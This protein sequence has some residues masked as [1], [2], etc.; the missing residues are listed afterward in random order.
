MASRGRGCFVCFVSFDSSFMFYSTP[1][2]FPEISSGSW[3]VTGL[4]SRGCGRDPDDPLSFNRESAWTRICLVLCTWVSFHNRVGG[5]DYTFTQKTIASQRLCRLNV[6]AG[7]SSWQSA[8]SSGPRTPR[9]PYRTAKGCLLQI[10]QQPNNVTPLIKV[11]QGPGQVHSALCKMA[12]YFWPLEV[13]FYSGTHRHFLP[14]SLPNSFFGGGLASSFFWEGGFGII[15]RH[16]LI[17]GHSTF[18]LGVTGLLSF[19]PQNKCFL[20]V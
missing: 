3:R 19:L 15:I 16:G 17:T 14:G 9:K 5:L 8:S 7:C 12:S 2:H 13:W 18:I 20:F 6:G 10:S 1:Q 11:R 4:E